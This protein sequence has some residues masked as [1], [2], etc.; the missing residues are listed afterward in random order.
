[1]T[2]YYRSKHRRIL[3]LVVLPF[4]LFF[5]I[6]YFFFQVSSSFIN[7]SEDKVY[8]TCFTLIN[9]IVANKIKEIGPENIIEYKYDANGNIIAVNANVVTMNTLNA[10]IAEEIIYK[11][12]NLPDIFVEIPLGSFFSSKLFPALGPSIP[13][14]IIPL[15]TVY[16]D[17]STEFTSTGINQTQHK[18]FI[19]V[20]CK[21]EV[22]SSLATNTQEINIEIP[23][24]E[25]I[26]IGNVP[27]TY[28]ELPSYINESL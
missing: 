12:S 7:L 15:S 1:M 27:N 21:L 11:L 23:I 6:L 17:Y 20:T 19:K 24:A 8:S 25:T 2:L 18:I 3:Y 13:L 4:T 10:T 28:V 9:S 5:I 16:T 26:I 22:L 14:K